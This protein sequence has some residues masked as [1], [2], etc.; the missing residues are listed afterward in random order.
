MPST[1]EY[2]KLL[3]IWEG[4]QE[5]SRQTG[6]QYA[7]SYHDP[8]TPDPHQTLPCVRVVGCRGA[9]SVRAGGMRK[10][11]IISIASA[12][13]AVKHLWPAADYFLP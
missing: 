10:V 8:F 7:S 5:T 9:S 11:V 6:L 12:C 4:T 2:M 13:E 1:R 3:T